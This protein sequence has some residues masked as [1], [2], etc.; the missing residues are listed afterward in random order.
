[1]L[2]ASVQTF[3]I[4]VSGM[5]SCCSLIR[6]EGSLL[7]YHI[8][9]QKMAHSHSPLQIFQN[10]NTK[11]KST[12]VQSLMPTENSP[13]MNYTKFCPKVVLKVTKF[14]TLTYRETTKFG[15]MSIF[16]F[17]LFSQTIVFE[18]MLRH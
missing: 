1:M 3:G 17:P 18:L 16:V 4:S 14:S 2:I 5:M 13:K 9:H 7:P 10:P 12:F 6:W 8:S 11:P 15:H